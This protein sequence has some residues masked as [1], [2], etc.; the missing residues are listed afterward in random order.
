ML[1]VMKFKNLFTFFLSAFSLQ[2]AQLKI[3]ALLPEVS[4]ENQLGKVVK[5][6]SEK[7]NEWLLVFFYPKALTGG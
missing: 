6:E 3:G 2:A 7:E 1:F 5:I 4:G